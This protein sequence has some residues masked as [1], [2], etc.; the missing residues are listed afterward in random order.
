M[1]AGPDSAS[2][3]AR[4]AAWTSRPCG[5]CNRATAVS[6][7][8]APT[9]IQPARA[10]T[11][12]T[13]RRSA[14]SASTSKQGFRFLLA[15]RSSCASP[16]MKGVNASLRLQGL[17]ARARPCY[18]RLQQFQFLKGT[19]MAHQEPLLDNPPTQEMAH[20][21]RDYERFTKLLKWGAIA[22]LHRRLHRPHD[23]NQL[24]GAA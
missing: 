17:G 18:G 22:C 5:P 20:H 7:Q 11:A 21:V 4:R 15:H 3:L 8:S 12:D 6:M 23:L 14:G 1:R 2:Q 16:T 19:S 13:S 9:V 10:A 24:A